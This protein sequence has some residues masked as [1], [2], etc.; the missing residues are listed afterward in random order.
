MHWAVGFASLQRDFSKEGKVI[1]LLNPKLRIGPDA[2]PPEVEPV[3]ILDV[4]DTDAEV[5]MREFLELME[6][7]AQPREGLA[8]RV[9]VALVKAEGLY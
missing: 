4:E 9:V 8:L 5:V 1:E 6:R 2:G 3:V 7:G